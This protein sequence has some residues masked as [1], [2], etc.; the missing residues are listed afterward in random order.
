M[1]ELVGMKVVKRR[2]VLTTKEFSFCSST[3]SL[4]LKSAIMA[5]DA[6]DLLEQVREE[7]IMCWICYAITSFAHISTASRNCN[8]RK[9]K[10]T[11]VVDSNQKS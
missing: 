10:K 8:R 5:S 9:M 4:K 7:L 11:V 2:H 3:S 6:Q 1:I